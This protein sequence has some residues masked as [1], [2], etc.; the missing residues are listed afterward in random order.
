MKL[1]DTHSRYF[2]L[3]RVFCRGSKP[4]QKCFAFHRRLNVLVQYLANAHDT[5]DSLDITRRYFMHPLR[6]QRPPGNRRNR[7]RASPSILGTIPYRMHHKTERFLRW[8]CS[9]YSGCTCS[10]CTQSGCSKTRSVQQYEGLRVSRLRPPL[11]R[12][13]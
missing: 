5:P 9:R 2:R 7:F 12:K 13:T 3:S 6:S 1:N 4:R 10:C 11:C 8:T